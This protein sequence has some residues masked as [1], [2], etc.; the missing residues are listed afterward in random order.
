MTTPHLSARLSLMFG[1]AQAAEGA[2]LVLLSG[3][4]GALGFT[5]QQI[6]YVFA[7]GALA[8]FISPMVAG[9][10]ADRYWSSQRFLAV[11]QLISAPLLFI[12]WLQTGFTGFWVAMFLF[13]LIRLPA[14]TLTNVVAFYHLG[15]AERFGY[16]RV[17]GTIGWLLVSWAL[18]L[19]LRLWENES[20]HLGDGLLVAAVLFVVSGLYSLSLPHTPPGAAAGDGSGPPKPFAFLSAFGLL[21][22]RNFAIIVGIAFISSAVSPFF[23]NFSFLFLTDPATLDLA[24]STANWA[25]SLGQLIE[26]IVLLGL[27]SSLRR[28]GLK[29]I[30]LVGIGA[31]AIRFGA[32]ALGG[33]SWLVIGSI[34]VHGFIFTFFFIGLVIAVEELSEPEYRASAQGLL[35]FARGGIGSLFG[36][37]VAGRV[38]DANALPEGGHNWTPVFAIPAFVTLLTLL[39]FAALFRDKHGTNGADKA[40]APVRS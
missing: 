2:A 11:C 15:R 19:Y 17:W 31:Q 36:Q 14:M 39:L 9:Y 22:Q 4:M 25:Q 10:L 16:V 29:R 5:G 32:F 38:Y 13:A 34:G 35:T 21:R 23:Y 8:S 20:V 7:T 37:M 40:G 28:L 12:A 33:P 18:S 26:I 1:L 3:H 27:A 30:L 6:S 24:P